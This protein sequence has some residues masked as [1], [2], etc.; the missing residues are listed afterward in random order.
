MISV[1]FKAQTA[2][3]FKTKP[4]ISP[5]DDRIAAQC[6]LRGFAA[7]ELPH[8]I[9]TDAYLYW[10]DGK[11]HI[12]EISFECYPA[13]LTFERAS[14][15]SKTVPINAAPKLDS[16]SIGSESTLVYNVGLFQS[17][18]YMSVMHGGHGGENTYSFKRC[19]FLKD[20]GN[21][22]VATALIEA[23]ETRPTPQYYLHLL[24]GG[25]AV[26]D[27]GVTATAFG[28]RD[29]NFACV[30]TGIWNRNED[31][32]GISRV[33]EEWIYQVV[34]SFLPL[35]SGFYA[36]DL[37]LD[38]RDA[39]LAAHAFGP[40][41]ERLLDLEKTWD[42]HNILPYSCPFITKGPQVIFMTTG[43]SGA[44][45]GFCAIIWASPSVLYPDRVIFTR[46]IS[47]SEVIKK[48]YA[49]ATG[50]DLTRLL[51]DRAY[52]EHHRSALSEFFKAQKQSRA[53]LSEEHFPRVV[54][55]VSDVDVL[56]IT[57]MR[58]EA[59]VATFSLSVPDSRNFES[60]VEASR[61]A[62]NSRSD[63]QGEEDQI[64]NQTNVR[65]RPCLILDN[66]RAGAEQRNYL[67][68]IA[69]FADLINGFSNCKV[70]CLLFP[71]FHAQGSNFVTY[72]TLLSR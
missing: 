2:P 6:K 17:E 29:W 67:P 11:L 66:E 18:L 64:S 14:R 44:G 32:T 23:I 13:R 9:S 33:A 62:R 1:T 41:Q 65:D 50:A 20:I 25:G 24:H 28:C 7:I 60:R 70:W 54:A 56:F 16:D 30:L 15:P 61:E 36:A 53:G 37:G 3:A 46:V 71:I 35:S 4:K 39:L 26:G 38:P 5:F 10:D 12:G 34:E 22:I 8:E 47:A 57:G 48:E 51:H 58:D 72:S 59:P 43:K 27:I 45:K 49:E 19:V 21:P 63:C 68:K 31:Q 42:P 69:Y 40:N 55:S 52:K